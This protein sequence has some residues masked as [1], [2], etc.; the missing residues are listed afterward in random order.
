MLSIHY[1]SDCYICLLEPYLSKVFVLNWLNIALW[2]IPLT[3]IKLRFGFKYVTMHILFFITKVLF[4]TQHSTKDLQFNSEFSFIYIVTCWNKI[5]AVR[6]QINFQIIKVRLRKIDNKIF[7]VLYITLSEFLTKDVL[8][9]VV[10]PT[11]LKKHYD[12]TPF[13]LV[14]KITL[15]L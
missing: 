13:N 4:Q 11:Y 15:W 9:Y 10:N 5:K 14:F 7:Y 12:S 6:P 8:E 1:Q 3:R 2:R